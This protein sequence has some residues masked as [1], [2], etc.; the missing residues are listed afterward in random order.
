MLRWET[1][2]GPNPVHGCSKFYFFSIIRCPL[3]HHCLAFYWCRVFIS[4]FLV[5]V[6]LLT[7]YANVYK[8]KITIVCLD[9]RN[10]VDS[11]WPEEQAL[12]VS[13]TPSNIH[14]HKQQQLKRFW[15][16]VLQN[17]LKEP[18]FCFQRVFGLSFE[19]F[20]DKN[21]FLN[22]MPCCKLDTKVKTNW[23]GQFG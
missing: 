1:D 6:W 5:W 11:N 10:W 18:T 15:Q 2:P 4:G 21:Y 22:S 3:V 16:P 9:P 7:R 17:N 8:P 23:V 19:S 13:P 20:F 14:Q 12:R